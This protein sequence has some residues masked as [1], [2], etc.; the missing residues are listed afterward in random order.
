MGKRLHELQC[1]AQDS[2]I[3]TIM[4]RVLVACYKT[5]PTSPTQFMI[6]FLLG[7]YF[8]NPLMDGQLQM[9]GNS[10]DMLR[11]TSSEDSGSNVVNRRALADSQDEESSTILTEALSLAQSARNAVSQ[12]HNTSE[13]DK[14][15]Q[16][17]PQEMNRWE[18]EEEERRVREAAEGRREEE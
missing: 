5:R 15:L 18:A 8:D 14:E 6:D 13:V 16:C 11:I 2:G 4:Q 17:C 1:Y 10:P 9:P 12:K 3:N 7:E